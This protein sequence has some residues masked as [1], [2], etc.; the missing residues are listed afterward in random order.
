MQAKKPEFFSQDNTLYEIVTADGLMRPAQE[1]RPGALLSGGSAKQ[2]EAALGVS[3]E[4]IM[5]C[6]DHI[7]SD[8]ALSKMNLRWRTCLIL[9]ELELVRARIWTMH[10]NFFSCLSVHRIQICCCLLF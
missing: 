10:L 1:I 2:I 4:D 7:Y 5:F 9:R 8:V 6:G 3:A